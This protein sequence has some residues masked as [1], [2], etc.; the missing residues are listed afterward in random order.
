V[1][2]APRTTGNAQRWSPRRNLHPRVCR[3][4]TNPG[5][6]EH[7]LWRP[8][9]QSTR[10]SQMERSARDQR[11]PG[12]VAPAALARGPGSLNGRVDSSRPGAALSDGRTPATAGRR[13]Y[14]FRR[15]NASLPALPHWHAE[16]EM[17]PITCASDDERSSAS[18]SAADRRFAPRKR[19]PQL[20]AP[21][22]PSTPP[23]LRTGYC[24]FA[25]NRLSSK[26]CA[27]SAIAQIHACAGRDRHDCS[28]SRARSGRAIAKPRKPSSR[29]D[30]V[31]SHRC[32]KWRWCC[33][34]NGVGSLKSWQTMKEGLRREAYRTAVGGD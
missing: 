25:R 23:C 20:R 18:S 33:H 22:R 13:C 15:P 32:C 3:C 24:V 7:A 9:P 34:G 31:A 30:P 1:A 28:R 16:A 11:V 2:S 6:T 29:L 10:R 19:E 27:A 12:A 8:Q 26:Q 5:S 14:C 4:E 17:K 21:R